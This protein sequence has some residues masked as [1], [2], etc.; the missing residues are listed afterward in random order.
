MT[1]YEKLLKVQLELKAPKGQINK[2][3]GYNYRSCEDILESLK[4]LLDKHKLALL[5]SDSI[6][7]H[8]DRNYIKAKA[9]LINIEDGEK[10]ETTAYAREELS[11]KGMDASQI[12]GSTSSYARKYALNGLFAIDDTK[13]SDFTNKHGKDLEMPSN[14]E[15]ASEVTINFGKHEGK[16]LA[17]IYKSDRNYFYWLA[18][19]SKEDIVKKSCAMMIAAVNKN[20]TTPTQ[21]QIGD[22]EEVHKPF[23]EG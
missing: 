16:T 13:D 6:V 18:K 14:I 21:Q 15:Q 23:N 19:N 17:E 20:S 4:P 12:T 7:S 1:I 5:I 8:G 3:G 11:K 2:F 22:V 9:T 10:I